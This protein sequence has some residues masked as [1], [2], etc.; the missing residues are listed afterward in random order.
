MST[1]L[2]VRLDEDLKDQA[3]IVYEQLGLDLSSAVR[4]FLKKS[5][6]VN[7]IPFDVRNGTE[8]KKTFTAINNMRSFA[9]DNGLSDLSLDEINDIIRKTRNDRKKK[10]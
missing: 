5:V 6:A 3:T 10:E 8:T 9:E 1:V 7:G 4:M 2:Q